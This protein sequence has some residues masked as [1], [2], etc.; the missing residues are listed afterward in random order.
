MNKTLARLSTVLIALAAGGWAPSV[1]AA[2]NP[3]LESTIAFSSNRDNLG[4][5]L[6]QPLLNFEV[7]RMR[8]DGTNLKRLTDN[9]DG[10]GF[11]VLSPQG[12]KIVFDSNPKRPAPVTHV[13]Q[14]G[15]PCPVA[16]GG[17]PTNPDPSYFVSDL[18]LMDT[19]GNEPTLLRGRSSSASW[20]W[21]PSGGHAPDRAH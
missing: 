3:Q 8:P 18:F 21:L 11:A 13:D 6:P 19:D 17:G 7:Y 9:T 10:D 20:A 15:D 14:H 2:G 12:T 16:P 1:A 4:L 5:L